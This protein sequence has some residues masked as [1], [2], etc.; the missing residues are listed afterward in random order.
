MGVFFGDGG[1][2][3]SY[4]RCLDLWGALVAAVGDETDADLCLMRGGLAA[5]F[6]QVGPAVAL[7]EQAEDLGA[8]PNSPW[9]EGDILCWR[10][11]L[12]LA[13]G[14]LTEGQ[15]AAADAELHSWFHRRTLA[16]FWYDFW[17]RQGQFERALAAGQ[18]LQ[19]LARNAGQE[20]VPG[21]SAFPLAKLGRQDEAST[22]VQESLDR[23]PRIHP[24]KRPHYQLAQA[25]WELGRRTEAV[26]HAQQAYRQAWRDGPPHC[27][28]WDLRD[29]REL[30]DQ[31]SAPPPDLPTVDPATVTVPLENEV[32]DVIAKLDAERRNN[33]S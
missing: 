18:E 19:R 20:T 26:P 14:S 11:F 25:L 12:A 21:A 4:L 6:G 27:H 13:D 1:A 29:A 33:A 7:L 28:Y 17:V 5:I 31:M 30:L 9:F 10:L 16:A 32:C 24:A 3:V 15:L 22:A 8:P 23:L 2:M